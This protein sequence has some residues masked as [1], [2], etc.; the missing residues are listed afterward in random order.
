MNS[1]IFNDE[2]DAYKTWTLFLIFV[3][4]LVLI[5][6]VVLLTHKKP[7]ANVQTPATAA[8]PRRGVRKRLASGRGEGQAL[9]SRGSEDGEDEDHDGML[10]AVGEVSDEDDED[11]PLQ[12][13][14]VRGSSQALGLGGIS[15]RGRGEESVGLIVKRE[16]GAD[17]GRGMSRTRGRSR[18]GSSDARLLAPGE[19]VPFRDTPETE[20]FGRW[21]V[22]GVR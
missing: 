13:H 3:S 17:A 4:I 14:N 21:E 1:L 2:V 15:R 9:R 10:W 12:H 8:I 19:E 11:E 5:S 16:T 18:S 7:E 22:G 20:E 6:G